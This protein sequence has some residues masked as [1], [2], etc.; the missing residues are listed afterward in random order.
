M[1]ILMATVETAGGRYG[2]ITAATQDWAKGRN[3]TE[4]CRQGSGTVQ[5]VLPDRPNENQVLVVV[6]LRSPPPES[7]RSEA[8]KTAA[9]KGRRR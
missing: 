5:F 4:L 3:L 9:K 2:E 7:R 1:L 6:K 8:T